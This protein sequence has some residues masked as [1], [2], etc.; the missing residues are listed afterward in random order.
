VGGL[1]GRISFFV[2]QNISDHQGPKGIVAVE[3]LL[4]LMGELG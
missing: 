1:T 3:I 4:V 2:G